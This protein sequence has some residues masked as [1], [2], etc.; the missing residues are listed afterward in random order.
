MYG[1]FHH[2][3]LTWNIRLFGLKNYADQRF[4][5]IVHDQ[6]YGEKKKIQG[7][8]T[9]TNTYTRENMKYSIT[10]VPQ[11]SNI[12][13]SVMQSC[14]QNIYNNHHPRLM[15]SQ[16]RFRSNAP[17]NCIYHV[18]FMYMTYNNHYLS[19]YK[20]HNSKHIILTYGLMVPR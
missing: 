5:P 11:R 10:F 3:P 15:T 8:K 17:F 14:G 6:V 2:T 9:E 18:F 4:I 7:K 20:L 16:Y 1:A 19:T 13:A 12:R